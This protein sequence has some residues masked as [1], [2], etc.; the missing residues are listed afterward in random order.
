MDLAGVLGAEFGPVELLAEDGISQVFRGTGSAGPVAV[1]VCRW[2]AAGAGERFGAEVRRM[3]EL[4]A[5]GWLVP[6]LG[7]GFGPGGH[8]YVAMRVCAGGSIERYLPLPVTVACE[9]VATVGRAVAA[10]HEAGVVHGRITPRKILVE[11]DGTPVLGLFGVGAVTAVPPHVV[12]DG[13]LSIA[14]LAPEIVHGHRPSARADVYGLGAVL[15]GLITGAA[16]HAAASVLE[17]IELRREPVPAH[18]AVPDGLMSVIR[19]ATRVEPGERYRD[20]AELIG[21][22]DQRRDG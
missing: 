7:S 2:P 1:K 9:V 22:V 15:H 19:R 18:P 13:K 20:V 6:L 8:A 17:E 4:S 14:Y 5:A 11:R 3:T 10:L 16:P 21:S 12:I